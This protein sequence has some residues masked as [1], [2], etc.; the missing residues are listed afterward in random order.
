MS[1]KG[2]VVL[3][4]GGGSGIGRAAAVAFGKQGARL[5]IAG[6]REKELAETVQLARDAGG[7]AIAVRADVTNEDDVKAL[8]EKTLAAYGRLDIAFNNAGTEG[9]FQPLAE[10]EAPA[11]HQIF[12]TNVKGVFLSMKHE[13]PALLGSGG[14]AI[15]NTSSIAGHVGFAGAALYAASKHA[16][17]GLTK[18]AALE[19][20]KQGV[21]VNAVA[22]G[23][24]VTDMYDRAF[25]GSAAAQ[26]QVA[27]AHPA[28]RP[29]TPEE[30]AN[31]VLWLA[32]DGASFV[33][34][35]SFLIDGG[36]TAQ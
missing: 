16:V 26:A 36:F 29:G 32:S 6:R 9:R 3:I 30:I 23:A 7:E 13:I 34:G 2:K 5:V 24:V 18:T 33:T 35:Q 31:A 14:G 4:T 22:P 25:G 17:E 10:A 1:A 28:G 27:A 20:A 21:R 19:L 12:D 15:I 8:V 11:Y